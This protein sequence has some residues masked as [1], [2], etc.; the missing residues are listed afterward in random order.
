MN[1][2]LL[3]CIQ[4]RKGLMIGQFLV[5][6]TAWCFHVKVPQ[7]RLHLEALGSMAMA[8]DLAR[9]LV[10]AH[11]GLPIG[12]TEIASGLWLSV[13]GLEVGLQVAAM[14]LGGAVL[15]PLFGLGVDFGVLG[16]HA[17]MAFLLAGTV[18]FILTGLPCSPP[19][20]LAQQIKGG[21]F[22]ALWGLPMFG[23]YWAA[24]YGPANW[25]AVSRSQFW[26][27]GLLGVLTV[28]S[29]FTT[30]TMVR[31]R[32]VSKPRATAPRGKGGPRSV[33]GGPKGWS[34]WL[35]QELL[36]LAPAMLGVL[37]A[38]AVL[39]SIDDYPK[40]GAAKGSREWMYQYRPLGLLC[41]ISVFPVMQM[42]AASLRVFR[43]LPV[44]LPRCALMVALRPFMAGL[45][46]FVVYALLNWVIGRGTGMEGRALAAF[47]PLCSLMSLLQAVMLRHPR[48]P[49]AFA[50]L[51]A[52]S[53][54]SACLPDVM[55]LA[56][57][58]IGLLILSAVF[59]LVSWLLHV[60]WLGNSSQIYRLNQ[61]FLR[62]A[63]VAQR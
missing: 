47:L 32:A 6:T 39:I 53:L 54:A 19:I 40:G 27:M 33:L 18:Q 8:W 9:G 25:A 28:A 30:R 16:V 31:E 55:M 22:G 34:I 46:V 26:I 20:N 36:C 52:F 45:A 58:S 51:I 37:V 7:A 14:L 56:F 62:I 10:R 50:L 49:V 35:E 44:P 1:P 2:L 60:R 24:F 3:D 48:L 12:R 21:L 15:G 17:M 59:L 29:W 41:T 63:G 38:A 61:G 57:P 42:A 11:V 43:G 13:V 23:A 4:R 5:V